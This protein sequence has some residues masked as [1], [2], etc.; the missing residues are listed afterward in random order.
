L[1]NVVFGPMGTWG[2]LFPVMGLATELHRRGHHVTV[3]TSDS[4]R[5]IVEGSGL[6]FASAGADTGPEML[7]A[8]TGALTTRRGGLVS[9]RELC[10]VM[11]PQ[12][13]RTVV[14]L[15]SAVRGAD[16]FVCHP[17]LFGGPLAAELEGV[18]LAT[19]CV[20]PTWIPSAV[21]P[22]PG[23]MPLF[24]GRDP[25]TAWQDAILAIDAIV[26]QRINEVRALLGLP[27]HEQVFFDV[28]D[29]AVAVLI[30]SS[31]TVYPPAPDWPEHVLVTGAVTWDRAESW[32]TRPILANFLACGPPPVAVSMGGSES[33][34][35]QGI[36]ERLAE[37]VVG[38]GHRA[39]VMTGPKPRPVMFSHADVLTVDFAPSSLLFP[40]CR[41]VVHHGGA[42]TM[43]TALE[44]GKPQLCLPRAFDHAWTAER[45]AALGAGEVLPWKRA[46]RRGV[47]EAVAR[48]LRTPAYAIAAEAVARLMRSEDGLHTAVSRLELLLAA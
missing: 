24:A 46:V 8:R 41:M 45:L 43:L 17:L 6:R 38:Q 42:G 29:R 11:L 3:A 5:S 36:Y 37:A 25:A 40:Q 26:G 19:A 2:E 20:T 35:P 4:Y 13:E 32:E 30:M 33:L 28:L 23:A 39:I 1:S 9:L 22:P 21:L 15:R 7:A 12:L 31:P 14:D 48:V 10:A 16:L 18:P 44:A 27:E 47:S 34:D